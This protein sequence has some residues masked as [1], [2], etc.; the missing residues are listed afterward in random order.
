M[1]CCSSD[2]AGW[3]QLPSVSQADTTVGHNAKT[4]FLDADFFGATG[5]GAL[6]RKR[7]DS[8]QGRKM[9]SKRSCKELLYDGHRNVLQVN[10]L[11][12]R[13]LHILYSEVLAKCCTETENLAEN[14]FSWA[15][16]ICSF[17][18]ELGL[19]KDTKMEAKSKGPPSIRC[20]KWCKEASMT[21]QKGMEAVGNKRK[22]KAFFKKAR[23]IVKGYKLLQIKCMNRADTGEFDDLQGGGIACPVSK[24]SAMEDV[25]EFRVLLAARSLKE[26]LGVDLAVPEKLNLIF[27]LC[28]SLPWSSLE[29]T[30]WSQQR[31]CLKPQCPLQRL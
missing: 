12:R 2:F 9:Y 17:A 15:V 30:W 26:G 25:R 31:A 5:L 8:E 3:S 13:E 11:S 19:L 4:P 29:V 7:R 18:A 10:T 16:K 27:L 21:K 24:L 1:F 23:E 14:K 6:G 20:E 28:V 22:K